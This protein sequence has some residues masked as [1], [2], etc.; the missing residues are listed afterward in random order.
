M[1]YHR[2]HTHT[3]YGALEKQTAMLALIRN[4]VKLP[5]LALINMHTATVL[6]SHDLVHQLMLNA[7]LSLKATSTNISLHTMLRKTYV[8]HFRCRHQEFFAWTCFLRFAFTQLRFI[9]PD[10]PHR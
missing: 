6:A 9:W 1:K 5:V 7:T 8:L 2:F 10:L 4:V 3:R